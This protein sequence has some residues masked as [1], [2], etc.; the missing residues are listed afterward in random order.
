MG[1][2][3]GSAEAIAANIFEMSVLK[4]PIISIVIGEGASGES[5]WVSDRLICLKILGFSNFTRRL[6]FVLGTI[7][8]EI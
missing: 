1:A 4:T 2:E 7:K 8:S 3:R 5:R 6:C